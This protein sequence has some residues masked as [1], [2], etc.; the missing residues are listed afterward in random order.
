MPLCQFPA[1]PEKQWALA[2]SDERT[3]DVLT[4]TPI[5]KG[6]NGSTFPV[7]MNA[8]GTPSPSALRPFTVSLKATNAP[9]AFTPRSLTNASGVTLKG[10]AES[11]GKEMAAAVVEYQPISSST[12]HETPREMRS[13][14]LYTTTFGTPSFSVTCLNAASMLGVSTRSTV[15]GKKPSSSAAL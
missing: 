10:S 11:G 1:L 5:G 2:V 13:V 9:I 8:F 3:Q 15:T 4:R 14:P 6:L 7:A 12:D